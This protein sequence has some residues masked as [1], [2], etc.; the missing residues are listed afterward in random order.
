[1]AGCWREGWPRMVDRLAHEDQVVERCRLTWSGRSSSGP[2]RYGGPRWRPRRHMASVRRLPKV[3]RDD[4]DG[5]MGFGVEP[6]GVWW[7]RERVGW[8][9][10]VIN[11]GL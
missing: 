4:A 2:D 11:R 9:E 8:P 1:M 7:A 6:I 3:P 10:A 5:L